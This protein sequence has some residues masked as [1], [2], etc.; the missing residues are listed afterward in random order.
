M[1]K[2]QYFSYQLGSDAANWA[3]TNLFDPAKVTREIC[4]QEDCLHRCYGTALTANCGTCY[5]Q[6]F[7]YAA[8]LSD[9]EVQQALKKTCNKCEVP[10]VEDLALP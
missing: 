7:E 1:T 6:I 8:H 9:P 2:T 10:P 5:D 3:W 4:E